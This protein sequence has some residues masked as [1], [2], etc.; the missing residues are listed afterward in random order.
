MPLGIPS[1]LLALTRLQ[2]LD[3]VAERKLNKRPPGDA[4]GRPRKASAVDS[5]DPS[6]AVN[7]RLHDGPTMTAEGDAQASRVGINTGHGQRLAMV[8][9]PRIQVSIQEFKVGQV[10]LGERAV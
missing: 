9:P 4:A 3:F 2:R 8:M 6:S 1:Y 10:V 7:V 5:T